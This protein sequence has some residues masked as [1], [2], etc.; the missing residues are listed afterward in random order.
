MKPKGRR[1]L[2]S[3]DLLV[4]RRCRFPL[5]QCKPLKVLLKWY[6][7]LIKIVSKSGLFKKKEYL[8]R[9]DHRVNS[10]TWSQN[11]FR[12]QK[13]FVAPSASVISRSRFVRRKSKGFWDKFPKKGT[14][15]GKWTNESGGENRRRRLNRQVVRW[16]KYQNFHRSKGLVFQLLWINTS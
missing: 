5:K 3:T 16:E 14:I 6:C 1:W 12:E 2:V 7:E 10:A 11:E 13:A 15:L 4:M 8:V 9:N